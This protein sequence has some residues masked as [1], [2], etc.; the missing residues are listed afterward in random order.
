MG[1]SLA[2]SGSVLG[3]QPL[4]VH[5]PTPVAGCRP[6]CAAGLWIVVSASA[7]TATPV[8]KI[9][10]F[11]PIMGTPA[12]RVHA[13]GT[14][15]PPLPHGPDSERLGQGRGWQNLQFRFRIHAAFAQRCG[16]SPV[17]ADEYPVP[18]GKTGGRRKS[19]RSK[20][21]VTRIRFLGGRSVERQGEYDFESAVRIVSG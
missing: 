1:R 6:A 20:R 11:H 9:V 13:G 4:S 19:R 2:S 12:A 18:S 8:R 7:D 15:W 17:T 3:F 5:E 16:P 14:K 10:G 21:H